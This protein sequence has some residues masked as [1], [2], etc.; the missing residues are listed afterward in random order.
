MAETVWQAFPVTEQIRIPELFS[1][2]RNYYGEGYE[3]SGETHN[4]WECLYVLS[5]EVCVSA[6][7]NVYNLT[8]GEIVFHKPMSLHKF[9]VTGQGGAELLI[10]SYSAQGP[11]SV[12]LRDKVFALSEAQKAIIGSMLGYIQSLDASGEAACREYK[13]LVPYLHISNYL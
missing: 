2:F 9:I 5:G 10:F 8:A 12:W 1:F 3:F 11:L 6:D 13:Y 7:E 4:F